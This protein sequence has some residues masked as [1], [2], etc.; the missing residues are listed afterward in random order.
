MRLRAFGLCLLALISA[1]VSAEIHFDVRVHLKS[2]SQDDLNS[3]NFVGT[4]NYFQKILTSEF[5][6]ILGANDSSINIYDFRIAGTELSL[7]TVIFHAELSLKGDL[8]RG[9]I[10]QKVLSSKNLVLPFIKS[11]DSPTSKSV[12]FNRL[13]SLSSAATECKNGGVL[14]PNATCVC[15]PYFSGSDC[16]RIICDHQ[17]IPTPSGDCYCPPG[18]IGK[19]CE[20]L[21]VLPAS[22]SSFDFSQ[23]S[24]VLIVD[25]GISMASKINDVAKYLYQ[26]KEKKDL[27]SYYKD[28]VLFTFAKDGNSVIETI[29]RALTIDGLISAF[30]GISVINSDARQPILTQTVK[31]LS[32]E[33]SILPKS[34][35]II[36]TDSLASDGVAF[37]NNEES[38]TAENK[39]LK[40]TLHWQ[41]SIHVIF[42]DKTKHSPHPQDPGNALSSLKRTAHRSN[43]DFVYTSLVKNAVSTALSILIE[44]QHKATLVSVARERTIATAN[45]KLPIND[46]SFAYVVVYGSVTLAAGTVNLDPVSSTENLA[47]YKVDSEHSEVKFTSPNNKPWG[48]R[49]IVQ[50]DVDVSLA[51]TSEEYSEATAN[52]AVKGI[53]NLVVINPLNCDTE[54]VNTQIVDA[55]DSNSQIVGDT[56]YHRRIIDSNFP[57]LAKGSIQCNPGPLLVK[58]DI[59]AKSGKNFVS[60]VPSF[61]YEPV[62]HSGNTDPNCNNGY[63]DKTNQQCVCK[64][65]YGGKYCDEVQCANRGQQ[66]HFP[67]NGQPQCL[68]EPGFDGEFCEHMKCSD[69]APLP[70]TGE[71]ALIVIIQRTFTQAFLNPYIRDG[72]K[73][74]LKKAPNFTEFVLGTYA[75]TLKDGQQ[76]IR[77]SYFNDSTEFADNLDAKKI[78]YLMSND[79]DQGSLA[80]LKASLDTETSS[81]SNHLV[82]LFTD[83]PSKDDKSIVNE[84]K[85]TALNRF[86]ELH[87]ISTSEY[88]N[89]DECLGEDDQKNYKEIASSTGG[90]YIQQCDGPANII[91]NFLEEFVVASRQLQ[92]TNRKSAADCVK[93]QIQFTVSDGT[94]ERI[95]IV[96]SENADDVEVTL[97]AED[98]SS[99]HKVQKITKLGKVTIFKV[100]Q[101]SQTKYNVIVA[102]SKSGGCQLKVGQES[103]FEVLLGYSANPSLDATNLTARFGFPL[104]PVV[105][106]SSQLQSD[107]NVRFS[108]PTANGYD[109]IGALR[110]EGCTF[111][112]YF[113]SPFSCSEFEKNFEA[114]IE[115]TTSDNVTIERSILAYCNPPES[116]CLHNGV[117]NNGTCT[118]TEKYNGEYCE[119][120]V[121]ENGGRSSDTLCQCPPGY[122]GEFCEFTLCSKWNFLETHDVQ[123]FEHKT[124]SFVV[125]DNQEE[126]NTVLMDEI[127]KFVQN[128]GQTKTFK[129]YNLVTFN[130]KTATNV[131]NTV[132][133]RRFLEVFKKELSQK[134][135]EDNS[136]VNQAL[137]GVK[138]AAQTTLYKPSII[139]LITSKNAAVQ[140]APET[141]EILSEGGVQVNVILVD[142]DGNADQFSNLHYLTHISYATGGRFIKLE[143]TS[144]K[145]LLS[146]Y[147]HKTVYENALIEDKKFH[148]CTTQLSVEFPVEARNKWY[149]VVVS[150]ANAS[151][152]I[153]LWDGTT[154]NDIKRFKLVEDSNTFI[155]L[156]GNF[157][158]GQKTIKIKT[159][160]G[161]CSVQVRSASELHT[162]FG[163]T[164]DPHDDFPNE[165]PSFLG[166]KNQSTLVTLK[167]GSA[168]YKNHKVTPTQLTLSSRNLKEAVDTVLAETNII[169]RDPY[170]CANQFITPLITVAEGNYDLT[171][172]PFLIK[173]SG[174]DENGNNF[175]R[176]KSYFPEKLNCQNSKGQTD[177]GSCICD[178]NHY[179]DE[180]QY[181]RCQHGGIPDLTVCSC[182]SGY[183]GRYCEKI[184]S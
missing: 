102:S 171:K 16:S 2:V 136:K 83:S 31:A 62:R 153:E 69:Q 138:L 71:R 54:K 6:K 110:E 43:G 86:T 111:D 131:I 183:Y 9:E 120:P 76:V 66:N 58:V 4:H 167:I 57:Y 10:V 25:N 182:P 156:I 129:H 33:G 157:Q 82:L 17:G 72:I 46:N 18:Y 126:Y 172:S 163:F 94:T 37:S 165:R 98:A 160:S 174:K 184:I 96:D 161:R 147:L 178:D 104:H 100:S 101:L 13:A 134:P 130:N 7:P 38:T 116:K 90:F 79:G 150:G 70:E 124:I 179:G 99:G 29:H 55:S 105:F 35:V 125:Q 81:S 140:N 181:P 113:G 151:E 115:I 47:L 92:I 1:L 176:I 107:L 22:R 170:R 177:H 173:I 74:A 41:H 21:P 78:E 93:E 36:V 149:S 19:H 112:Y 137:L 8:E 48:Y 123:N 162:D 133:T 20:T 168:L 73:N 30:N 144:V 51:F 106:V 89:G 59:K 3:S 128:L 145:G 12:F 50:T 108:V 75:N 45:V 85:A 121:C 65:F 180:C 148:D 39:L 28:F 127:D 68:C 154:K 159:S 152:N 97:T 142:K 15:R 77:T 146:N 26:M 166:V 141:F 164:I 80:A 53:P 11:I 27:L 5:N 52:Y 61:C 155:A 34:N 91:Q 139:Y 88:G 118:C 114:N 109:D 84:L 42:S 143:G 67:G 132:S 40:S 122:K 56:G 32:H 95:V 60:L 103:D 119:N 158:P 23:R 44:S 14:L 117:E 169:L 64:K 24:L 63:Y 49:A 87:I 135:D 175:Q